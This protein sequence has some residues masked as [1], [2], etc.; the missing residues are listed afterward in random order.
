[1]SIKY[2]TG[3]LLDF[4]NGINAIVHVVNSQGIMGGGI[5]LQIKE[6]YPIAYEV[7]KKAQ[8]EGNLKLGSM[9]IAVLPNGKKIINACAQE[10]YGTEKRQLDYE[11]FY[12]IMEG[13]KEA[14]EKA[15][16]EGRKHTLGIPKNIGCALAGGNW[17]I[18]ETMIKILFQ[19]SPIEVYIVEYNKK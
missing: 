14:L 17:T 4:D 3:N 15:L 19:E 8:K 10:N 13:L 11:A 18:C 1:M 6:E 5:A 12:V 16:K 7:Y 2:I 9:S